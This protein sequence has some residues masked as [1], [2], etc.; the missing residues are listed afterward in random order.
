MFISLTTCL[1]SSLESVPY[2]RA[3]LGSVSHFQ[4]PELKLQGH[5]NFKVSFAHWVILRIQE[6]HCLLCTMDACQRLVAVNLI[7]LNSR[8]PQC[9]EN[10][11]HGDGL[12]YLFIIIFTFFKCTTEV[13]NKCRGSNHTTVIF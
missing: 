13:W 3:P 8:L 1:S 11:K 12:V 5:I 4:K 9:S 2:S 10:H 7:G 6:S